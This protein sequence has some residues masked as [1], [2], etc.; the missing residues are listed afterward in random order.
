MMGGAFSPK[1]A[2]NKCIR[3]SE[4]VES[5][6]KDLCDCTFGHGGIAE[7]HENK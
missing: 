5:V 7:I 2:S 1:G 4:G 6:L 3:I